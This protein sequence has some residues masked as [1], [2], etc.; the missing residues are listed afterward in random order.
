MRHKTHKIL[1]FNK[2][3][4][5]FTFKKHIK[6]PRRRWCLKQFIASLTD[7]TRLFGFNFSVVIKNFGGA[8]AAG[9]AIKVDFCNYNII[10]LFI[11]K[12]IFCIEF[13][14]FVAAAAARGMK[15][16]NKQCDIFVYKP[17]CYVCLVIKYLKSHVALLK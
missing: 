5:N 17:C 10:T 9:G 12:I 15:I 7:I 3:N 1:Q 11:I 16:E 2:L 8:R 14:S 13:S 4:R 6:F